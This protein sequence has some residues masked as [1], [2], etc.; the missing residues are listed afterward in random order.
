MNQETVDVLRGRSN[1][2]VSLNMPEEE[3]QRDNPNTPKEEVQIDNRAL[4]EM[5]HYASSGETK[6]ERLQREKE[7]DEV[8]NDFSRRSRGRL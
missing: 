8:T 4:D 6:S 5:Y 3:V 2:K 7:A 1:Y